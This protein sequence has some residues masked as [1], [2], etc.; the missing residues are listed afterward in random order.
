MSCI[1]NNFD[2]ILILCKLIGVYK[3]ILSKQN[4]VDEKTQV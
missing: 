1:Y 2:I 3:T 4:L